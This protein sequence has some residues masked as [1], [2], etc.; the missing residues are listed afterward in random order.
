[1][2][3]SQKEHDRRVTELLSANNRLAEELRR[4]KAKNS[5]LWTQERITSWARQQFPDA[6]T[7]TRRL[8]KLAEEVGE[9]N[10][11][12]QANDAEGVRE[13]AAD[14]AIVL[15]SLASVGE[16]DLLLA[17]HEKMAINTRRDWSKRSKNDV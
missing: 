7:M 14:V 10:Q 12:F 3:I 11:S 1:M 16:F 13:E 9:L 2:N 8:N 6:M 4:E 5:F 17:I 15:L